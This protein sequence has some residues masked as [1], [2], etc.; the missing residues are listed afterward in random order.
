MF[1]VVLSVQTLLGEWESRSAVTLLAKPVRRSE[2]LLGK[3]LGV[4]GLI[5]CFCTVLTAMIALGL[6]SAPGGDA[7]ESGKGL[8]VAAAGHVLRFSV[9]AAFTFLI[10]TYARSAASATLLSLGVL[11]VCQLQHLAQDAAATAVAGSLRWPALVA[12]CCPNFQVFDLTGLAGSFPGG[13]RSLLASVAAYALWQVA[14]A[15]L[16]AVFSFRHREI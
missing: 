11:A 16:L 10:A 8:L 4:L 12:R 5:L 13:D 7:G 2:Y 6:A 15:G 9:L 1:T 3:Y 14:G